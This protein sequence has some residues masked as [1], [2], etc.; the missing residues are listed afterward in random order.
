MN[1]TNIILWFNGCDK[2]RCVVKKM[3]TTQVHKIKSVS[4]LIL[5]LLATAATVATAKRTTTE[6]YIV[7]N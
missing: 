4:L 1:R 2:S 7:K 6:I 5:T 3:K